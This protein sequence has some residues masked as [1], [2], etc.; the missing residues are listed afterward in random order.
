MNKRDALKLKQGDL[1]AW[2]DSMRSAEVDGGAGWRYGIVMAV[3]PK[4]GIRVRPVDFHHHHDAF[5]PRGQR[6][7]LNT[8]SPEWVPYHHV[9]PGLGDLE[10]G[11]VRSPGVP[12]AVRSGAR[13][14]TAA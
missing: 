1:I 12:V 6:E 13:Y 7:R 10:N 4:G 2:G 5:P 8:Y 14:R 9:H 3:T 11:R